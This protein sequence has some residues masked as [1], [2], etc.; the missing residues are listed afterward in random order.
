MKFIHLYPCYQKEC[1]VKLKKK[2]LLTHSEVFFNGFV[3][4]LNG[5][6]N[7]QAVYIL[8]EDVFDEF[9]F[10]SGILVSAYEWWKSW[11]EKLGKYCKSHSKKSLYNLSK[12]S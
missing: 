9:N 7:L 4:V 12:I 5:Y 1:T 8:F 2:L 11:S 10:I 6:V 3:D